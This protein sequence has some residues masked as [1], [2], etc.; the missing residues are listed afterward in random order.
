MPW[1]LSIENIAGIREAEATLKPGINAVRASNWQGKSSFLA[2]IETVFGTATPLTDGQPSGR[3]ALRTDGEEFVVDLERTNGEVSVRG[4]PYLAD[5][6]DQIC[7]EL[8]AFLD[9][10]NPVRDAVRNGENLESILTEPLDFENIEGQITELQTERDQVER[11][12]DRAEAAAENVPDYQQQITAL[13]S[14]LDELESE[15]ASIETSEDGPDDAR[16]RLS[17]LRAERDTVHSKVTRLETT[18]ERIEEKLETK[19]AELDTI[20]VPSGGVQEELETLHAEL[21]TIERDTELL[22]SVYEANKRVL[23]EGR[24]ELL[25]EVSHEMLSDTVDCWVCGTETTRDEIESQLAG[26]DGRLSELEAE[27]AEL[28]SRVEELESRREEI[29]SARRRRSDLNDAIGELETRLSETEADLQTARE[30]RTELDDNITALEESV[31]VSNDRL[32]DLQSEIK[33]TKAELEDKREEL[34]QLERRAEQRAMLE[35]EYD[36]LTDEIAALR[37]RKERVKRR[38]REAFSSALEA[39][40]DR[41]DTGFETA[42]L[43]GTFE[44][45]VA[46]DGR[47]ARLDALS[48]GERE[49]LGFVAALAGHEA[50]DVGERVPVLLLDRLGGLAGDNLAAFVDYLDGRAP[51]LVLTAYP[52]HDQFDGNELSP[53]EWEVVS[54]REV[55]SST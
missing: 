38:T 10:D 34:E 53:S 31:S 21:R 4:Q 14:E 47:E 1:Q 15:R 2:S 18:A 3:V 36:S 12:L 33:Y 46:R 45:V 13:E 54:H 28:R 9:E 27:A 5:E 23:D 11:E 8:F 20:S 51:Y 17:D 55:P 39:V 42:R 32:T 40:L 48:E 41:F 22:Q 26:L 25:T 50:F 43:T 52:E 30:R 35:D 49:L 16:E 29:R 37:S 24:V 19:R 6:Y 7:A 44:L